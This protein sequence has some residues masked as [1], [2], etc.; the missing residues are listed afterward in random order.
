MAKRYHPDR[1]HEAGLTDLRDALE[2]IFL[3]LGEAYEVLRSP[4]LRA[5][6]DKD[7][8]AATPSARSQEG[9][10]ETREDADKAIRRAAASIGRERYWE[11][12]PLLETAVPRATGASKQRGRILL[13]RIYARDP[14]WVK[15]AEEL[16]L[17]VVHAEPDAAEAHF[18]LG[19]IYRHLGLRSRALAAFRRVVEIE[20]ESGDAWTQIV[21]L[22]PQASVPLHVRRLIRG[23]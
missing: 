20:P 6:Y 11:A 4:R 22:D 17:A 12:L 15:Q 18:Y 19:V 21:E 13:A 16:L 1:H 8:T 2:A 23:R 5:R 9:E 7:L 3:R 14:D 10:V